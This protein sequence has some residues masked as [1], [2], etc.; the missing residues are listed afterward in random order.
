MAVIGKRAGIGSEMI[1]ALAIL[2]LLVLIVFVFEM[3]YGYYLIPNLVSNLPSNA[4]GADAE[5]GIRGYVRIFRIVMGIMFGGD[6]IY[7]ILLTVRKEPTEY[8]Y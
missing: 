5:A 8:R 7:M 2:F 1:F 3:V 6:I 4:V